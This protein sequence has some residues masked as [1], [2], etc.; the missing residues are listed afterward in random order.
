M[1]AWLA[2]ALVLGL[3][4]GGGWAC[5]GR[6]DE[7][8]A[9]DAAAALSGDPNF[10]TRE[11]SLTGRKLVEVLAVR[12]IGRSSTEVEFTWRDS[13]LPPGQPAPLRTSAALFRM[14][15]DGRWMLTSLYKVD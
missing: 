10:T 5:G 2:L 3:A 14:Q 4:L 11:R 8:T 7:L 13:P 12:R 15:D 6:G 1:K 9:G